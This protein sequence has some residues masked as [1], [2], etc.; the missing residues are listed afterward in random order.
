MRILLAEDDRETG[1]WIRKGLAGEGHVVD[2][3]LNG[4]EA[5]AQAMSGDYDM[6]IV[7]R[8]MPGLDGLS[9]VKSL[10]SARIEAPVILLTALGSVND[11]VDGL[12]A[13]AEDYVVKPFAMAELS[14]RIAAIARRPKER[15][16]VT[17]LTV[18]P[19]HLD[20]ITRAVTRDGQRIDLQ[21]REF[22]LLRHFMERPGRVQ[23]RAMLLDAVWGIHFD[24]KTS[25]VETHTSRLRAKIDKPFDKPL[26]KTLH[27][28]G[29]VLEP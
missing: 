12:G 2:H 24:P 8:M 18:G 23:T 26:L 4:R 6:F 11:K 20:L 10:C 29:Y 1:E 15:K 17:E 21:P 25:V 14:A 7:D 27:G 13:G 3:V 16:E 5:L 9:L 22:L 19:L 28:V